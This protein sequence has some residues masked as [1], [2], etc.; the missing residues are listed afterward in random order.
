MSDICNVTIKTETDV[1]SVQVK[2][3][4][5]LY[6]I[7]IAE[8]VHFDHPCGGMGRCK[9][10]SVLINGKS[11]LSCRYIVNEDIIVEI[12]ADS[13]LIQTA[14][15]YSVGNSS[16]QNYSLALDIGTT[17]LAAA[18]FNGNGDIIKSGTRNNSQRKF[19][20]DVISRIAF[21]A[22]N[23]PGLLQSVLIEDVKA[24]FNELLSDITLKRAK[25]LYVAGNTTMLHTFLGIDCSSIGVSPYTPAFLDMKETD[26]MKISLDFAEKIILLPGIDSFAGADIVS[27]LVNMGIPDNKEVNMLVDL[28][29]NAECV[30]YSTSRILCTSAAAGPCF[31]GTN[32][33]CGMSAVKGAVCSYRSDGSYDVIGDCVPVGICATGLIDVVTCLIEKGI[34]DKTGKMTCE[35]FNISDD[36]YIT[37]E[38][39]RHYQLAKSAVS[40]A[41]SVLISRFGI[42][43]N[44]IKNFYVAGGISSRLNIESAVKS[45]LFP[46]EIT[47]KFVPADNSSLSGLVKYAVSEADLP[48]IIDKSEYVDLASD[49]GFFELFINNMLFN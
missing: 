5:H 38:D 3:G 10:C 6:D 14:G 25:K 16:G 27:G 12:N 47:D 43:V 11:E 4:S 21:C 13:G 39:I 37:Q 23:G 28:G 36:V 44:E 35:R 20:P 17:T 19:G 7:I 32:I 1:V 46:P 29:T 42:D 33:T 49:A 24:L 31:E 48:S 9:K 26:G 2:R 18:V 40:S 34:V 45:G 8:N 22:D 41:V 30:I 15:V